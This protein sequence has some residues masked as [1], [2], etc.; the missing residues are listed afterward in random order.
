MNPWIVRL[1]GGGILMFLTA[2]AGQLPEE[3][4]PAVETFKTTCS[5]CHN[6]PHPGRHDAKE[7]DHYLGLMVEIMN[8]R[9]VAYS[10]PD[11][12]TIRSYLH[13][14]ARH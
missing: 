2:C 3:G 5:Q 6:L 1:L 12:R 10:K 14:N 4:T 11:M 8:E 9:K 13:R 7:W